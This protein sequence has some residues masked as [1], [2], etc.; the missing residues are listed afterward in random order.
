MNIVLFYIVIFLISN[1]SSFFNDAQFIKGYSDS[2]KLVEKLKE[3][4]RP[5]M[6]LIYSNGCIHCKNFS[7]NY[8]KISEKMHEFVDFYSMNAYSNYRQHFK[9]TGFPTIFYYD[10]NT[11]NFIEHKASRSVEKIVEVLKE[12]Y[13]DKGKVNYES[14]ILMKFDDFTSKFKSNSYN[15]SAVVLFSSDENLT[16]NLDKSLLK[17]KNEIDEMILVSDLKGKISEKNNIFNLEIKDGL[18]VSFNRRKSNNLF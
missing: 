9:I 8:I 13:I 4:N 18:I 12:K 11:G 17:F 16:K 5:A 1:I 2:S 15:K 14:F 3:E 7:P 6:V 10:K